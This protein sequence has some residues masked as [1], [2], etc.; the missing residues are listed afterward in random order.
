MIIL[1]EN[2]TVN[3]DPWDSVPVNTLLIHQNGNSG[4]EKS[5]VLRPTA[6]YILD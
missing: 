4:S 2:M 6:H 5:S 1:H 3:N